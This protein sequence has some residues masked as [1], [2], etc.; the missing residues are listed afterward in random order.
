MPKRDTIE[1]SRIRLAI[2][3]RENIQLPHK[4]FPLLSKILNDVVLCQY[5][6]DTGTVA[7]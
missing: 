2:Q 6:I 3:S 1:L 7:N 5:V 4:E